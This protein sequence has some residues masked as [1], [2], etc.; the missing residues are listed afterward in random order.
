MTRGCFP[1]LLKINHFCF[2]CIKEPLNNK[3]RIL[4]VFLPPYFAVVTLAAAPPPRPTAKILRNIPQFIIQQFLILASENIG[5]LF[6]EDFCR[7]T[8]WKSRRN[9]YCLSRL[10]HAVWRQKDRRRTVNIFAREYS[11]RDSL[12]SRLILDN[13][14]TLSSFS[15]NASATR[16]PYASSAR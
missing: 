15:P 5:R 7:Q 9:A 16:L 2:W 4:L 13:S 14:I 12:S 6:G 10:C 1:V 11:Y 8:V 3:L